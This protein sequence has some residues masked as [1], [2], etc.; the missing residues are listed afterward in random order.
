MKN[1]ATA[2]L[3]KGIGIA[4]MLICFVG[5][6][7]VSD[8]TTNELIPIIFV[9]SGII[10]GIMFIGFGEIISLLQNSVN[11]QEEILNYMNNNDKKVAH[12]TVLQDIEDNLPNM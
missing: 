12:K 3:L 11:K 1:N 5:A 6:I 9:V 4:I 8:E 10:S 7:I 2:S